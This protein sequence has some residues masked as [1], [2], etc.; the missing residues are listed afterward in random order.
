MAAT[1]E[2]IREQL[3]QERIDRAQW[4]RW[5]QALPVTGDTIEN[6]VIEMPHLFNSR[7]YQD[8]YVQSLLPPDG[9][10]PVKRACVVWHRRA[11][12]DKT[13]WNA[14][15]TRA[16]I[17]VGY[18]LYMFPSQTQAKRAIWLGRGGDKI[19]FMD[20]IPEDLIKTKNKT[21][22]YVELINGSIIQLGGSDNFDAY[23]GTNPIWIVFSEWAIC[24]PTAWDYF[25]PIL[26]ENGGTAVFIYTP[27]GRNH[28]WMLYKRALRGMRSDPERWFCQL[29]P[30]QKTDVLTKEQVDLEVQEEGM[31]ENKAAQEFECSFDAEVEGKIF[32]K[33][34]RTAYGQNRIGFYPVQPHLPVITAWDIGHS[35]FTAVWFCQLVGNKIC[36]VHYYQNRLKGMPHYFAYARNWA[37][38]KEVSLHVTH[39]APHDANNH[40]WASGGEAART[41]AE[42]A[43]D[44]QWDF[45]IIPKTSEVDGIAAIRKIF[46]RIHCDENE[47]ESGLAAISEYEFTPSKKTEAEPDEM[48]KTYSKVPLHNWASHGAKALQYLAQ[49][50]DDTFIPGYV[51]P[52]RQLTN[53]QD[54]NPYD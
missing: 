14:T 11:G 35:D 5:N 31:S 12:K 29:L 50:L 41:V 1:A 7:D 52:L 8:P 6:N 38:Q 54:W 33:E 39:F 16:A 45:T 28:G 48:K 2:E 23:M 51:S 17:E 22:L 19:S 34:L 49:G 53:R 46:P 25:R 9:G 10:D 13:T 40:V 36:L 3:F 42:I 37:L 20:H 47:C 32:G 24:N 15:I 21:E 4:D 44:H 30:Y 27:R 26:V 18:Y 43:T